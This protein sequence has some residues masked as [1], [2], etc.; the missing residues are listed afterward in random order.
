MVALVLLA[1]GGWALW[2]DRVDRDGKGFVSFGTTELKT[3]QHAIVGDLRGDGP[4]W[5]Y[6]SAILGDARV[7]ATS[8]AEQPLFIG[9]ARKG[10]VLRYLRQAGYAT[11]YSFEVSADTTHPGGAP[12][13]PPSRES[14]WAAS[15]Q[16]TG[17]QTLLWTPRA[18]DWSIVFMNADASANVDVRG[19]AGAKLP[20]LPWLAGALL[21]AAA[22]SGVAGGRVLARAIRREY[23]PPRSEPDDSQPATTSTEARSASDAG[24]PRAARS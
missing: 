9:I 2:K 7:R 19:D 15:T 12:S 10:D 4:R 8:P 13:G 17:E 6:G 21:I 20:I 11:I 14:F 1:G 24:V 16:G 5:L 22:A 23:H 3:E 18:G